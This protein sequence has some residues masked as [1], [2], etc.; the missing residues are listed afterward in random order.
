LLAWRR[1]RK[2]AGSRWW[3]PVAWCSTPEKMNIIVSI[4]NFDNTS[5]LWEVFKTCKKSHNTKVGP[6]KKFLHTAPRWPDTWQ[7]LQ[8]KL[9][10][11]TSSNSIS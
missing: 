10:G 4:K 11:L 8:F 1:W 7:V 2:A 9:R 6:H 5:P 3:R